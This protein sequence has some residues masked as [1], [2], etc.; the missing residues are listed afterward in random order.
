MERKATAHSQTNKFSEKQCDCSR[1]KFPKTCTGRIR[2]SSSYDVS[3]RTL[4]HPHLW[5]QKLIYAHMT[6]RTLPSC[7]ISLG[8]LNVIRASSWRL[9]GINPAILIWSRTIT[10]FGNLK[11]RSCINKRPPLFPIL[12]YTNPIHSLSPVLLFKSHSNIIL[13]Y[14]NT[15]NTYY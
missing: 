7:D 4:A 2:L 6:S 11:F 14:Q 9:Y 5:L 1:H 13:H 10:Q 12:G 8:S 3:R 15:R